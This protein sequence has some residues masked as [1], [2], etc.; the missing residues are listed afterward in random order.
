MV[1]SVVTSLA[2]LGGAAVAWADTSTSTAPSTTTSGTL[3]V[4]PPVTFT[5]VDVTPDLPETPSTVVAVPESTPLLTTTA[6]T[7]ST[8]AVTTSAQVSSQVSVQTSL[9]R[10]IQL[11]KQPWG[12][13]QVAKVIAKNKFQWGSAQF[14]CLNNLW[15]KESGWRYRANNPRTGAYGIPQAHPG[16]KMA[17][18]ASDWRTNP[19]TQIRWGLKY[20]DSR[21]KNPCSAWAKFK[22]SNWY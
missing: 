7:V 21:Y 13:R 6:A 1:T 8:S 18:V 10:Q 4:A 9:A 14:V 12:A 19:V 15:T 11:A 2:L 5:A 22:R 20:I 3:Q 16:S 17:T